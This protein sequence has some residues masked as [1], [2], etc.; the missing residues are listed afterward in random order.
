MLCF[1]KFLVANKILDKKVGGGLSK[2]F[3]E[4]FLSHTTETF[5]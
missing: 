4:S 3:V 1:K 2:F 5:R